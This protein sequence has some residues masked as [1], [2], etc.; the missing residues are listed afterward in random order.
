MRSE[1]CVY[2]LARDLV[3]PILQSDRL[4]EAPNWTRDG[5]ALSVNGD[6]WLYRVDLEAP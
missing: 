4:I 2:D 6:G 1:L 3:R 5:T